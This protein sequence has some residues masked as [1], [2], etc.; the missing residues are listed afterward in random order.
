MLIGQSLVV[1]DIIQSGDNEFLVLYNDDNKSTIMH[2]N[3]ENNKYSELYRFEGK[4]NIHLILGS[5]IDDLWWQE[6]YNA[7]YLLRHNNYKRVAKDKSIK[8][9]YNISYLYLRYFPSMG[10][11]FCIYDK[12][13]PSNIF[14]GD[15]MR[16]LGVVNSNSDTLS[17]NGKSIAIEDV[18]YPDEISDQ[19]GEYFAFIKR[20]KQA[21][22]TI[23]NAIS[24]QEVFDYPCYADR[25]LSFGNPTS[26]SISY[27]TNENSLIYLNTINVVTKSLK[28]EE[29]Y[30]FS[31]SIKKASFTNTY[32][33]LQTCYDKL[34][35]VNEGEIIDEINNCE[36][37]ELSKSGRYI[38]SFGENDNIVCYQINTQ[39]GLIEIQEKVGE[40]KG[41]TTH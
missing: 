8:Y 33:L 25:V 17:L 5:T 10:G 22:V 24:M 14:R 37:F 2:Y 21:V 23:Y 26:T 9:I 36:D 40:I 4:R 13:T 11:V 20:G 35:I 6:N 16:Y 3:A 12:Y 1:R 28:K 18:I 27:I 39:L 38:L 31:E 32:I 7:L 15:D 34:Y 19:F 30:L 41:Q 29:V